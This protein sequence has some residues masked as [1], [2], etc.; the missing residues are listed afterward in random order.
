MEYPDCGTEEGKQKEDVVGCLGRLNEKQGQQF[1]GLRHP[2]SKPGLQGSSGNFLTS[3][4]LSIPSQP[5]G[6]DSHPTQGCVRI[7][8]MSPAN[9]R[10]GG[11]AHSR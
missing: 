11:L 7:N 3:R 6:H 4:S 2:V 9:G 8:P 10:H 1:T 5:W